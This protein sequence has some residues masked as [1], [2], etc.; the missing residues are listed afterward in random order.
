MALRADEGRGKQRNAT[1]S[2]KQA[3]DPWIPE[4][5]NPAR[6]MSGYCILNS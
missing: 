5:G 4:W 6:V 1:G 3:F 2:R